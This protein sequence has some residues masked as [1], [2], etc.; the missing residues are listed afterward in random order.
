[1]VFKGLPKGIVLS[2]WAGWLLLILPRMV[3]PTLLPIIEE[4]FQLSHRESAYLMS[5][6]MFA[7][8]LVQIPVG[9][10]SDRYG[11]KYFIVGSVCGTCIA[12]FLMAFTHS[13]SILLLLRSLSG[14]MA[15][16]YYAPSTAYIVERVDQEDVG[17]TLGLVFT[18]GSFSNLV[19]TF[20]LNVLPLQHVEWQTF[21]IFAATPGI[22]FSPILFNYLKEDEKTSDEKID[23]TLSV[24]AIWRELN[25]PLLMLLFF[26][27]FL[28]S[29][30]GWSVTTFLPTFFVL[31]RGFTVAT[32]SLL[33]TLYYVTTIISGPLA[34]ITTRKFGLRI[35]SIITSLAMCIFT[36]VLPISHSRIIIV[37]MLILWGV[38]GGLSWPAYN[39]LLLEKTPKS[40]HGTFLGLYNLLTFISGT[41]GP[42]FF[43]RI[44]DLAGFKVFFNAA[45]AVYVVVLS[46]TLIIAKINSH[47]R[48][49]YQD[50]AG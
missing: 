16:M 26:Y 15:G 47:R 39:A 49:N 35:P 5:G 11:K 20:L 10:L 13:F 3:V 23:R 32:A 29:L 37:S 7:Y 19:I 44:A 45:F 24:R 48:T 25:N 14:L 17:L 50:N 41:I 4:D 43:R 21:F 9:S 36:L 1:M 18:G 34:G 42:P 2:V 30:S 12:A 46:T 28:S 6:Y 40:H 31:E 38:L 27:N 22:L 33:I 8:A